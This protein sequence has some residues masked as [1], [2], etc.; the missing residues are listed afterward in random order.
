L[1]TRGMGGQDDEALTYYRLLIALGQHDRARQSMI[2]YVKKERR[3]RYPPPT[4]IQT[5]LE[6]SGVV[7]STISPL[8]VAHSQSART[9]VPAP[10]L[11]SLA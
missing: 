7:P 4:A 2:A 6:E 5:L 1:R 10:A 11:D 8:C 3:E 9:V